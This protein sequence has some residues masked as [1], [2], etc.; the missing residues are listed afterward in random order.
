MEKLTL[1][2]QILE[3]LN[4]DGTQF[5]FRA[6]QTDSS[7]RNWAKQLLINTSLICAVSH[8]PTT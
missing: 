7:Q 3:S 6:F 8:Q 4:S 2:V 5:L 1:N